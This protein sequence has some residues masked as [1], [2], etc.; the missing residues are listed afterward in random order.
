M[1]M[2]T[3]IVSVGRHGRA[4]GTR[5]LGEII[6][7]E[8][9][10]IITTTDGAVVVDFKDVEVAS[11][12]VLDSIA[13]ALRSALQDHEGRFFVITHL[14]DD[15]NETLGLVLENRD[16]ALTRV[17]EG[18][19]ELLGGRDHLERTLLAAQSFGT[20]TPAQLAE[21]LEVKLPN[22]HH[23]LN[24]LEAAGAIA[25]VDSGPGRTKTFA[26]APAEELT[27]A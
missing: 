10:E 17:D 21:R 8:I 16:M 3:S 12:P 15:V 11:S 1:S 14:N 22:L 2:N 5:E 25:R 24:L 9:R 23:R 4:L 20:F 26:V 18:R 7:S 6:A 27:T 13:C 19:L